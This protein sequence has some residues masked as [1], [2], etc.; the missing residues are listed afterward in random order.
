MATKPKTVAHDA[1]LVWT[2]KL[3]EVLSQVFAGRLSREKMAEIGGISTRTLERYIAHPDFQ[4][5]LATMRANLEATLLN[6]GVAYVAKESRIIGLSQM[7]EMARVQYETRELLQE[8]RQIG[9]DTEHDEPLYLINEAFNKDAH[10]AYR[11]SLNDIAK[12]LGHRQTK[13]EHSGEVDVNERV[14]FYMPAPEA[15]PDDDTH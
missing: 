3:E 12:E 7:A 14:T 2:Q 13:V 15:P 10:A 5:K 4:A 9:Y 1:P 11:E 6:R 8:K